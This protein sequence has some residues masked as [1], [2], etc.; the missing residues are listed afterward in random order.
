MVGLVAVFWCAAAC[1]IQQADFATLDIKE[2]AVDHH[3]ATRFGLLQHGAALGEL[4]M[5][6]CG[7]SPLFRLCQIWLNR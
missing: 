4:D 6:F 5:R 1:L 7:V 3:L 2:G